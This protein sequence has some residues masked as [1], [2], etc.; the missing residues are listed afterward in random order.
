MT[1]GLPGRLA[2]GGALLLAFDP[3][4]LVL[5]P[6]GGRRLRLIGIGLV[7]TRGE[8]HVVRPPFAVPVGRPAARGDD[9][10]VTGRRP[11]FDSPC[12]G[13]VRV[14]VVPVDMEYADVRFVPPLTRILVR[15]LMDLDGAVE[16]GRVVARHRGHEARATKKRP[17]SNGADHEPGDPAGQ[18]PTRVFVVDD[19]AAQHRYRS[20]WVSD[21]ALVMREDRAVGGRSDDSWASTT[22]RLVLSAVRFVHPTARNLTR[23][24]T[25]S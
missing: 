6:A 1:F 24:I 12:A 15:G 17:K 25:P 8:G 16:A 10:S 3:E 7:V 13:R 20:P 14:E 4:D 21:F 11:G 2:A 22:P 19:P 18:A 9:R 5:L 23:A